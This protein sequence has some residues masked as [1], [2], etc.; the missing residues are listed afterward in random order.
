MAAGARAGVAFVDV[1]ADFGRFDRQVAARGPALN[2]QM[3][4]V[5]G[6][7]GASLT[8]AATASVK[9]GAV[10]AAA[11]FVYSAQEGQRL[12]GAA[13]HRSTRPRT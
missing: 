13:L 12:R 9:V 1:Q 8:R 7:M 4:K 11:A 3:S 6:Q 5:G 10:G 2:R